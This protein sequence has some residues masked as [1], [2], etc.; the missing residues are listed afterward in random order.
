MPLTNISSLESHGRIPYAELQNLSDERLVQEIHSGNA[1]AFAVIFKRFHRLVHVTALNI[2]RDAGEAEDLTQTVFLEIYRRLGQFDPARGTLKVWLLQFAYS[3]SMHRRNYL[4]VRRFHSHVE[5]QAVEERESLWSPARLQSQELVRLT[6]EVI[7]VLPQP[8]RQTIEMY[9]FEGL[10]LKEIAKRRN[11]NFS[12]VRHH[13]YRGLER[14][15][16]Y[17]EKRVSRE[18]AGPAAIPSREA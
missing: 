12:N 10:T 16:F 15:R 14:L 7:A 18:V 3:R 2:L 13:Y 9:F 11:E 8:Q 1:D 6:N 5:L 4:F 17:L